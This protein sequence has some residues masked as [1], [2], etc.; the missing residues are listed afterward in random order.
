M[1][2]QGK[3]KA[4]YCDKKS[5]LIGFVPPEMIHMSLRLQ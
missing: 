4:V 1:D 3:E 2:D 5:K